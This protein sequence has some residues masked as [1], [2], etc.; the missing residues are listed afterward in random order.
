MWRSRGLSVLELSA[1]DVVCTRVE[2]NFTALP[3]IR[4]RAIS[5]NRPAGGYVEFLLTG[6]PLKPRANSLDDQ[7]LVMGF[8]VYTPAGLGVGPGMKH[9]QDI[10]ALFH[11]EEILPPTG[12]SDSGSIRYL[13]GQIDDF[14]QEKTGVFWQT[15]LNLTFFNVS[16]RS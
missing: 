1:M 15:N 11:N 13:E 16:L 12:G 4:N 5:Q 2:T 14:G 9:A 10:R 8:S 7:N 3:V 6:G